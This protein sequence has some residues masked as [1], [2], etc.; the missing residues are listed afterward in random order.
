M[1]K[2]VVFQLVELKFI[3]ATLDEGEALRQGG[4]NGGSECIGSF[5]EVCTRELG[6]Y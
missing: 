3:L 2:Y 1:G 6:N 5:T 4:E